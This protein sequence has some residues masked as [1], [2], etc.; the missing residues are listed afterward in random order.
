M[1]ILVFT[2]FWKSYAKE[3]VTYTEVQRIDLVDQIDKYFVR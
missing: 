2:C 1:F 3:L